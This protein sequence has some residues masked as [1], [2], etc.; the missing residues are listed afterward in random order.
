M[1]EL[2]IETKANIGDTVYLWYG[3]SD[4]REG[5]VSDIIVAFKDSFTT[6]EYS[7]SYTVR[8]KESEKYSGSRSRLP[9]KDLFLSKEEIGKHALKEMG[10]ECSIK[11]Q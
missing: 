2:K 8:Y 7:L 1:T 10:L 11:V 6:G 4:I 3:K 5:R 9:S